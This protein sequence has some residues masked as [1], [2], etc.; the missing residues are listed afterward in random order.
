MQYMGLK[1]TILFSVYAFEVHPHK[2]E[3]PGECISLLFVGG[4]ARVALESIRNASS[5]TRERTGSF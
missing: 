3:A 2:T 5:H 4:M 1:S